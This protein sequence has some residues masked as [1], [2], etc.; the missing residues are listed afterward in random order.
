MRERLGTLVGACL[1]LVAISAAS[2]DVKLERRSVELTGEAARVFALRVGE[3]TQLPSPVLISYKPIGR[4]PFQALFQVQNIKVLLVGETV[5]ESEAEYLRRYLRVD[6]VDFEREGLAFK[7]PATFRYAIKMRRDGTHL[8][9]G[10][11]E[12]SVPE[13]PPD[14]SIS[15]SDWKEARGFFVPLLEKM[16][17]RT[18][19]DDCV[20]FPRFPEGRV[21][22]D[23]AVG[24]QDVRELLRRTAECALA[25]GSLN[26]EMTRLFRNLPDG[27]LSVL[28]ANVASKSLTLETG[29][30]VRGTTR[31]DG[32]EFLAIGG[33]MR[34]RGKGAQAAML[35]GATIPAGVS[36]DSFEGNWDVE[37]LIDLYSG[38]IYKSTLSGSMTAYPELGSQSSA[39]ITV[40]QRSDYFGNLPRYYAVVPSPPPAA[41]PSSP[42][43][44]PTI[45][46]APPPR[47][48]QEP[49]TL[50]ALYRDTIGSVFTVRAEKSLGTAFAAG[51]NVLI[52]SRHV[53]SDSNVVELENTTGQRFKARVLRPTADVD[54]AYLVPTSPQ[55][56]S[57]LALASDVPP[58]GTKL[59]VIGSPAGLDGTLTTGT[60]SQL[61]PHKGRLFL[62][63]EGFV[64]PGNSGGPIMDLEGKVLGIV[65]ARGSPEVALGINIGVSTVD[66]IGEAPREARALIARN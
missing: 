12:S 16:L 56:L 14:P 19:E 33:P 61:R 9:I 4:V 30:R 57:P 53:V 25:A 2:A 31:I 26:P 66:V 20:G 63:F 45:A 43:L 58:I 46:P 15:Q 59:V 38:A 34:L 29:I 17:T 18:R 42:T 32:N 52:T 21:T 27:G 22:N 6:Y 8:E 7:L 39:F 24:A 50:V 3:P 60:V 35:M 37:A 10:P 36:V 47:V 28:E 51:S 49:K 65:M 5:T 55:R 44:P 41:T 64:S 48:R 23:T 40:K 62:Q 54:I 1:V 11:V 13:Q